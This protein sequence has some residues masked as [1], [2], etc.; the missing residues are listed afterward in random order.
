M[1]TMQEALAALAERA[2]YPDGETESLQDAWIAMMECEAVTA[3]LLSTA[4][5]GG[6][7]SGRDVADARG[8]AQPQWTERW[9]S[10][11]TRLEQAWELLSAARL[12]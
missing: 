4:I 5:S 7:V 11:L 1:V 2:P 8:L 9:P 10:R 12:R 6:R 3:G